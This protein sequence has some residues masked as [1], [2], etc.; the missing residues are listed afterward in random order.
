M[1]AAYRPITAGWRSP[2]RAMAS[3]ILAA[4]ALLLASIRDFFIKR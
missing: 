1:T 3:L 2:G 4:A